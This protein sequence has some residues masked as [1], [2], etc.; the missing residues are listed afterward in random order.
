MRSNVGTSGQTKLGMSRL[1][2]LFDTSGIPDADP[3]T[4]ATFS[5]YTDGATDSNSYGG[6]A[7][8]NGTAV[9]DW[10]IVQSSPASNTALVADD[11]NNCGDTDD[12]DEGTDTAF[13]PYNDWGTNQYNDVTLNSTGLGWI[14]VDGITKLGARSQDDCTDD[15]I[16]ALKHADGRHFYWADD[17]GTDKDPKLSVTHGV[18]FTPKAITMF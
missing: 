8:L 7:S 18:S 13:E 15:Y 3:V 5:I 1:F 11:F 2:F 6:S 14:I 12:P 9:A 16:G 4:A 17:S 10:T